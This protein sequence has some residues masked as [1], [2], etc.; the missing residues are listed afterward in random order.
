MYGQYDNIKVCGIASA[1]PKRV[2]DN[3]IIAEKLGKR[4]AKKQ[5]ELTGIKH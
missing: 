1:A 2:V 4:R 3:E 5:V